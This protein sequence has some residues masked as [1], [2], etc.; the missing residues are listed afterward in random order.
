MISL[1]TAQKLKAARL[2]WEPQVLDF[3]QLYAG[4]PYR[5]T[6]CL[7]ADMLESA[8]KWADDEVIIFLPRLDQLLAEIEKRGWIAD[9]VAVDGGYACDIAWLSETVHTKY[10]TFKGATREEAAALALLWI[11]EQ[12]KP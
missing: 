2:K 11:L 1:E 10:H 7:R 4:K 9:S 5:E 3:Y 12:K 8:I 6:I